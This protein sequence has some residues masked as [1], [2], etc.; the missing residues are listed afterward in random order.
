M[1]VKYHPP[2]MKWWK[3][4]ESKKKKQALPPKTNPMHATPFDIG[5]NDFIAFVSMGVIGCD[6]FTVES[7]RLQLFEPP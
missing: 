3:R 2:G 4:V 5:E 6:A 7:E 1:K